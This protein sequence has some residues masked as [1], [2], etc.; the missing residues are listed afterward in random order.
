LDFP[1]IFFAN[2]KRILYESLSPENGT[3]LIGGAGMTDDLWKIFR[4]YAGNDSARLFVIPTSLGEIA[5]NYNTTFSNIINQFKKRGFENVEALHTRDPKIANSKEFVK[6]LKQATAVWLTGGRQWR[7]A[8]VYINT[9][10]HREPE[11]ILDRGGIVGGHSAGA[12]I[13]G[14]FL[15]KG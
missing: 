12:S 10:T 14:S 3:L 13:Q 7:T 9:L 15:V 5:I 2:N 11:G 6:P 4:E 1:V 8:D